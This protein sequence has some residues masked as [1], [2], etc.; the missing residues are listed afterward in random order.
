MFEIIKECLRKIYYLRGFD[1]KRKEE[2]R[3]NILKA[4]HKKD[5]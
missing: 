4:F 1:E 2:K 3:R 5:L